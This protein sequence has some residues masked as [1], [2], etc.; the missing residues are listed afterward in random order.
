MEAPVA[1]TQHIPHLAIAR[2]YNRITVIHE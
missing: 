2:A 1:T